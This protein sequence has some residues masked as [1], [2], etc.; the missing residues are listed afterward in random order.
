MRLYPSIP[1]MCRETIQETELFNGLIL[2][3]RSQINI[4]V[5]DIHRNPKYWDN[6]NEFHP[7]R[8]LPENSQDRHTYA[9]I[10]FSAGQRNCL[11]NNILFNYSIWIIL[12][13]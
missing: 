6:P 12:L 10:P 8:F 9:F 1:L 3:K 7:E 5:F 11:G 4:H 13:T 2:P